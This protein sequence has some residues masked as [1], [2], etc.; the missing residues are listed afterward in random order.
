MARQ[1]KQTFEKAMKQLEKIVQELEGG[2]LPLD[3]AMKKF[4]QG[5]ELSK[6]CAGKLD[7]T[8][9]KVTIL[10]EN[11]KGD[12]SEHPFMTEDE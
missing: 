2:A 11:G 3:K 9:E 7:E 10:L 4:E 8:E 5:M 12:V 1:T 6:F